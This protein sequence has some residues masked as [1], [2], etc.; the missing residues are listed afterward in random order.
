MEATVEQC[1]AESVDLVIQIGE[2][3]ILWHSPDYVAE[4]VAAII[5]EGKSNHVQGKG[6]NDLFGY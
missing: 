2:E 4:G 5:Q 1:E 6:N 3:D